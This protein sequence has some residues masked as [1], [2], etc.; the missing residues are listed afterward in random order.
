MARIRA[1]QETYSP[2]ATSMTAILPEHASGDLLILFCICSATSGTYTTPSGWTSLSAY[3]VTGLRCAVFHKTAS[4]SAETNPSIVVSSAGLHMVYAISVKDHD[5]FDVT[6]I[7]DA[8]ADGTQTVAMTTNYNG[9]LLIYGLMMGAANSNSV[10]NSQIDPSSGF[11]NVFQGAA[12]QAALSIYMREQTTAGAVTQVG[13][14]RN[15][16]TYKPS[17]CQLAIKSAANS[18]PRP[19]PTSDITIL[20]YGI[21]DSPNEKGNTVTNGA[22]FTPI[23]GLTGTTHFFGLSAYTAGIAHA[24]PYWRGWRAGGQ[25]GGATPTQIQAAYITLG[26]AVDLT[27]SFLVGRYGAASIP[28]LYGH[29]RFEYNGGVITVGENSDYRSWTV[30]AFD[31]SD[32]DRGGAGTFVID[33]TSSGFETSATPP[34][35]SA[36]TKIQIG[37]TY[38]SLISGGTPSLDISCLTKVKKVVAAGGSSADPMG[39]SDFIR[40]VCNGFVIPLADV[41]GKAAT[42]YAPIQIGGGDAVHAVMDGFSIQFPVSSTDDPK[43]AGL[44]LGTQTLGI[45]I[46]GNAGDTIKLTNGVI[47][48]PSEFH[49]NFLSTCSA[50]ATYDFTGLTVNNAL[51]TLRD[52]TTFSGMVFV[53]C[54]IVQNGASI[55]GCTFNNCSIE[56]D[57]PG[58]IQSS[59]FTSGGLSHRPKASGTWPKDGN[60]IR[61]LFRQRGLWIKDACLDRNNQ[62]DQPQRQCD[63]DEQGQLPHPLGLS[64]SNSQPRRS[65]C[66]SPRRAPRVSRQRATGIQPERFTRRG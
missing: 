10:Q 12:N 55:T 6:V 8:T 31:Q 18:Q 3:Q 38:S 14:H 66:S 43:A 11:A 39:F 60:R 30:T 23:D 53:S 21:E 63:G 19:D 24:N 4:S 49:F 51:V 33:M 47:S 65:R 42:L 16:T 28:L 45:S 26:A 52:V 22:T 32:A 35:L 20:E 62:A 5:G 13:T 7:S 2:S 64:L 27:D 46:D 41:K 59:T 36:I 29:G 44:H 1:G 54:E 37:A 40:W 9:S 15:T 34:D 61:V 50:S 25:S 17:Y 58:A 56:S 57:D 48:S